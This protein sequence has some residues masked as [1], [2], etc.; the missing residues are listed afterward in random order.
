MTLTRRDALSLLAAASLATAATTARATALSGTKVIVIGAGL[1]GLSAARRLH[2]HGAEVIVLEAGDRIGGRVRTDW[3]LGAPFEHGAGWI[4]GPH[5]RNP[6]RQL[7]DG[8]D[9]PTFVTEDDSLEVFDAQ[10]E[11]LSA[12]GY[13][14]LETLHRRVEQALD[15]PAHAG[16]DSV[17]Q[18]L[19]REHPDILSD[20]LGRWMLSAFVEFDLGAGIEDI[21]AARAMASEAFDGADVV[22]TDGYDTLLAPLAEGLDCRLGTPVSRIEH[23]GDGVE[24]DGDWADYAICTVPLG[25]LKAGTI[26]FDPPLPPVLRQAIA[27]TGF[28]TVSKI[29]LRFA[30][31]F[32]DTGTQYFGIM[33]DPKGRW[34]YWLNYRTFSD[35]NILLGLS[36]GRY[37]PVADAMSAAERVE[38]ALDVL[39]SVWGDEVGRPEAALATRWSRDPHFLG[40]YSYPQPG[41]TPSDIAEFARPV[42]RRLL[43]AGEHSAP[44]HPGTTHGALMS[45]Q[46]AADAVIAAEG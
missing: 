46:R 8:I 11:P 35:E 32:W 17:A 9:A 37:A 40:A 44:D 21:S 34:P 31:P 22:L 2:D 23:V 45:G 24:V 13:D 6:I 30:E 12:A 29:A 4:H 5:P 28:G 42:G 25:V 10:G 43:F 26:A 41:G 3:S 38:D 18:L 14:R 7:A 27:R 19:G 39:R 16:Q 20:P 33:T 36:F 1:A 15:D